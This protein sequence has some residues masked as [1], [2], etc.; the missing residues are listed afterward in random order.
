MITVKKSLLVS[1]FLTLINPFLGLV[2]AF[3]TIGK[4]DEVKYFLLISFFTFLVLCYVPPYQDLYR[5]YTINFLS[6]N[7]ESTYLEVIK[8]HVD[9]VMYVTL[10]FFKK[11]GL[12]FFI[13]PALQ[14]AIVI[15]MYLSSAKDLMDHINASD[16]Y[17]R[18]CYLIV[19]LTVNLLGAALTLR[20]AFGVSF[21]IRALFL[22][23]FTEKKKSSCLYMMLSI[24]THFS[25]IF[26]VVI[27][28]GSNFLTIRKKISPILAV[29]AFI[30]SSIVLK[31]VLGNI[32]LGAINAYASSGYV[33][34]GFADTEAT[35]NAA[36]VSFYRYGLDAF[37]FAMYWFAIYDNDQRVKRFLNFV[38][39]YLVSCFFITV[40]VTA[41]N[42]YM[43]NIGSYIL[44]IAVLIYLKERTR[45]LK[46]L[47][48]VAVVI[49]NF[50]FQTIYLQRRPIELASLWRGLYTPAFSLIF[51]SD[52]DFKYYL[53]YIN[54]DGDW[55]GHELGSG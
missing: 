45:S 7:N 14:S 10:L 22:W 3:R 55:I 46:T 37:L 29:I 34:G 27:L 30:C 24:L 23:F 51:Y 1:F 33:D 41:F 2:I 6:Y 43:N 20:Y 53:K 44:L 8:G 48:L 19:F 17:R 16:K 32:N 13:Y 21:F 15:F 25:M 49:V 31:Y 4:K 18:Y 28:I 52:N 47:L 50:A 42:R 39:V 9:I 12:P 26:P 54:N 5:R 38:N 36:L 40:S 35:G 11:N